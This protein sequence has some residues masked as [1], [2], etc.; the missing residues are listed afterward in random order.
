MVY[1]LLKLG[2][3]STEIVKMH[4]KLFSY[5][6]HHHL[7]THTHLRDMKNV[8]TKLNLFDILIPRGFL[9]HMKM[10]KLIATLGF[11]TV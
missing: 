10:N 4:M 8:E 9:F 11:F 2:N 1:C 7:I 3:N 5:F 6:T